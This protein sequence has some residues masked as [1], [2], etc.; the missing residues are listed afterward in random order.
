MEEVLLWETKDRYFSFWKDNISY[1]LR[2][3]I[4]Y[5]TSFFRVGIVRLMVTLAETPPLPDRPTTMLST[6]WAGETLGMM[7]TGRG[8]ENG[9]WHLGRFLEW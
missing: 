2:G 6:H 5:S 7:K 1:A 4:F 9:C 3:Y 8:G